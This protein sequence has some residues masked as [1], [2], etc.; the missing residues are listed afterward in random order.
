MSEWTVDMV[1]T[2]K[3]EAI[4]FLTFFESTHFILNSSVHLE[5]FKYSILLITQAPVTHGNRLLLRWV[6]EK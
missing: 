4:V 1:T 2:S 6:W 5:T 3:V